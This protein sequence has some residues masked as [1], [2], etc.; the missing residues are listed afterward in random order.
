RR[1][2]RFAASTYLASIASSS[3][4]WSA[5]TAMGTSFNALRGSY[6]GTRARIGTDMSIFAEG[7]WGA[8]RAAA[9]SGKAETAGTRGLQRS[10]CRTLEEPAIGGQGADRVLVILSRAP[11]SHSAGHPD[12]S[13]ERGIPLSRTRE[14]PGRRQ[15]REGPDDHG[16]RRDEHLPRHRRAERHRPARGEHD[17]REPDR[18]H[19]RDG[20][21][22]P[23]RDLHRTRH[24]QGPGGLLRRGA[25]VD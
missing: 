2:R 20:G 22:P 3:I 19:A 16:S 15:A 1:S 4:S 14:Y 17:V 10:P 11:R 6:P 7:S 21:R 25:R 13:P 8:R 18:F 12:G 5:R 23:R 9:T 24:R